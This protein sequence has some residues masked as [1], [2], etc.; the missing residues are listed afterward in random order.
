MAVQRPRA[1]RVGRDG[2]RQPFGRLD[3]DGM[4]A[5]LIRSGTVLELHPHAVQV[6]RVLHHGVVHENQA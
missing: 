5:W 3:T 6:N 2:D 1:G 4:L